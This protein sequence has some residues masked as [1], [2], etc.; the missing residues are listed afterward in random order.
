[1][2]FKR[3]KD[4][5]LIDGIDYIYREDGS[6]NWQAMLKPEH[7]YVNPDYTSSIEKRFSKPWREVNVKD[8]EDREVLVTLAGINYLAWLR[9]RTSIIPKV[10]SVTEHD[11]TST[12]I[13]KFIPNIEDLDGLEVGAQASANVYSVSG[14]F[15]PF[16][17]TFAQNRAFVRA[18]RQALRIDILGKDE[19]D[20][21]A[22]K[23][24]EEE[25]KKGYTIPKKTEATVEPSEPSVIL[26][27][28]KLAEK[29]KEKGYSFEDL[30]KSAIKNV[31]ELTAGTDPAAWTGFD[32]IDPLDCFTLTSKLAEAKKKK[33]G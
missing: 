19:F 27:H 31:S 24:H 23:K 29:C 32:S 28:Q 9:G 17:A 15:Q 33:H 30:Q 18:V 20:A 25:V 6:I 1:M 7:L 16:L 11:V 14:K 13:V 10:D 2:T 21:E 5:G 3:N 26:P 4:T 8:L 12:C 22:S